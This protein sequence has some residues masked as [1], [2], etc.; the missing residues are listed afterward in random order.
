MEGEKRGMEAGKKKNEKKKQ[1]DIY[2]YEKNDDTQ[3]RL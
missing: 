2:R 1:F 3:Q